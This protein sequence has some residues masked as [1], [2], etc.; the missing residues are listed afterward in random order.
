MPIDDR[1]EKERR[2]AGI[3][4]FAVA[5]RTAKPLDSD[6]EERP[7]KPPF[8]SKNGQDGSGSSKC[9][10]AVYL[11]MCRWIGHSRYGRVESER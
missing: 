3:D 11:R 10:W 1:A 2:K 7:P 4:A 5:L 8:W 6:L 9:Q